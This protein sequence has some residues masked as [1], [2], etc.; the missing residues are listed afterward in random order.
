MAHIE[1]YEWKKGYPRPGT[2]GKYR[3]T[4]IEIL[5]VPSDGL[6]NVSD[7]VL[8]SNELKATIPYRVIS[9]EFLWGRISKET[10]NP[11]VPQDYK[12]VWIHV[13]RLTNEEYEADPSAK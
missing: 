13:R 6:P 11:Q 1:M 7:V 5:E 9:R 4:C 12:K 3:N 8:I 10:D 2:V